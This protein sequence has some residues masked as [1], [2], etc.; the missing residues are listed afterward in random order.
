MFWNNVYASHLLR[1]VVDQSLPQ[2]L[3][4]LGFLILTFAWD[5]QRSERWGV[6]TA[7]IRS[8]WL[9]TIAINEGT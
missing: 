4:D 5:E 2:F 3:L 9:P 1:E 7:I 6:L 8:F